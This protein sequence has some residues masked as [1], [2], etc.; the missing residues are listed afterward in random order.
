LPN[1]RWI[2]PALPSWV[3]IWPGMAD[4]AQPC[5]PLV[6]TFWLSSPRSLADCST[7]VWPKL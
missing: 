1:E 7:A 6:S 2:A 5:R 4:D 3:W